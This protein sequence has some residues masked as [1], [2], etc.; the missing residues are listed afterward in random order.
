MKIILFIILLL[1]MMA[2]AQFANTAFFKIRTKN[3]AFTTASQNVYQGNC[4]GIVTLLSRNSSGTAVNVTTTSTITLS[5]IPGL[6]Y[7]TDSYCRY[8]TTS[9]SIASGRNSASFYFKST[10]I[11]SSTITASGS[12][13][14]DSSQTE[15]IAM[16]LYV[17]KGLGADASWTTGANWSGGVAPPA[18]QV[19]VFDST[20]ASNCSPTI[21][22]NVSVRGIRIETGYAGTIT[23]GSGF[24]LTIGSAAYIQSAGNFIGGNSDINI[25]GSPFILEGGTFTSTQASLKLTDAKGGYEEHETFVVTNANSFF[26]NNGLVW[27]HVVSN[28]NPIHLVKVAA[29]NPFYGFRLRQD[30]G[31]TDDAILSSATSTIVP[32][33]LGDMNL[34]NGGLRGSWQLEGNLVLGSGYGSYLGADSASF[35]FAGSN[36]QTIDNTVNI[37]F[38]KGAITVNK[39][40]TSKVTLLSALTLS[41]G[42]T[43]NVTSGRIDLG[44][45]NLTIPS[46]LTLS[47][48]GQVYLNGGILK[49]GGST[50]AAGAYSSGI[51]YTGAAP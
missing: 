32:V 51:V 28:N 13:F 25:N 41:S 48:S 14:Q 7:Y 1:P 37:P 3:L 39:I 29:S 20:C 19:A 38:P 16:N 49:V 46:T 17:W 6:T 23:Q 43:V 11:G 31:L 4:S 27:F 21:N 44:G 22:S 9:V 15:T 26:H 42:Q 12:G 45:F 10:T 18:A 8:S 50:I 5:P 24:T 40:A 2:W 30:L 34:S 33:I 47:S 36:N 35:R